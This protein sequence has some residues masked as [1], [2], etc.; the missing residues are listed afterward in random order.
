MFNNIRVAYDSS[1]SSRAAVQQAFELAQSSN[2]QVTIMS[3][4][5]SV[6]PL[7]GLSGVNIDELD[8]ELKQWADRTAREGAS[9][10]PDDVN[11]HAVTRSGHPVS[12][13]SPRSRLEAT[14]SSC[15]V[16]AVAAG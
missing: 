8:A 5:P 14:T 7:G 13:S 4:A 3:V 15:S 10:A 16:R 6:T 9:T 1:P 12:K 11:V 2:A